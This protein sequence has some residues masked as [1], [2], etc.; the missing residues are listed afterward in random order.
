MDLLSYDYVTR[1]KN[2]MIY[3]VGNIKEEDTLRL[4]THMERDGDRSKA[5]SYINMVYV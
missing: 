3:V 4:L 2:L 1:Y 5:R